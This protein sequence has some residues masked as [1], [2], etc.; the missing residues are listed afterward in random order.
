MTAPRA[1]SF[2]EAGIVAQQSRL[3]S[4]QRDVMFG[5]LTTAFGGS[6]AARRCQDWGSPAACRI[7]RSSGGKSN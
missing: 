5:S 1:T 4:R 7:W 2:T 6:P 3:L